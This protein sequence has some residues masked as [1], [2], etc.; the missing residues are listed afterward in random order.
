MMDIAVKPMATILNASR[1][2]W[3]RDTAACWYSRQGVA[4]FVVFASDLNF[5]V[6][7]MG[8]CV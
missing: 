1:E 7:V 5:F 8:R 6:G 4:G 3:G 2:W